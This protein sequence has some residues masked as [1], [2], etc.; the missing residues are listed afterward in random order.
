MANLNET[1]HELRQA[2]VAESSDDLGGLSRLLGEIEATP[3]AS[4]LEHIQRR[5]LGLAGSGYTYGFPLV[6]TLG[7]RGE[8]L[9]GA[10]LRS[11]KLASPSIVMACRAVVGDLRAEFDRLQ[12][13]YT[14][15]PWA[16]RAPQGRPLSFLRWTRP[17]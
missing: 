4:T 10:L 14:Q 9:C 16:T 3:S 2:Y 8:K 5:F 1:L 13:T 12:A 6:S 7:R 11:E 15:G 17:A